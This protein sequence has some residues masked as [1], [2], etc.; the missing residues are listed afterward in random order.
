MMIADKVNTTLTTSK[1]MQVVEKSDPAMQ[2][3]YG[4]RIIIVDDEEAILKCVKTYLTQ[5]GYEVTAAGSASQFYQHILTG[6]YALAIIDLGL[7]DQDGLVLAEYARKNTDMRI[8][9]FT[10][11][12][13]IDDHLS[14][15]NAGADLYL[16]KPVDLR[17]LSATIAALLSRV[18]AP[19]IP[20]QTLDHDKQRELTTEPWRLVSSKRIL[21]SPQGNEIYLTSKEFDL[22]T[23]LTINHQA[24]HHHVELIVRLGYHNYEL[25]RKSLRSLVNR[26]RKKIEFNNTKS[27]IQTYQ[28]MGYIFLANITIE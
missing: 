18:E 14:A 28:G 15:Q 25:G 26:L 20:K 2:T 13:S 8:I 21:K 12:A 11:R 23:Q 7:P 5:Q 22:I 9:I 17:E 10:G 27:P 19:S 3:C 6:S 16:V 24:L 4:S 1:I